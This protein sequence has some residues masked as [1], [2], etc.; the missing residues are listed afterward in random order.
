MYQD[1]KT[2]S[3]KKQLVHNRVHNRVHKNKNK[4]QLVVEFWV[5]VTE[6]TKSIDDADEGKTT[7][8]VIAET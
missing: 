8:G 1:K 5:W 6:L 3:N 2:E 4:V 7:A